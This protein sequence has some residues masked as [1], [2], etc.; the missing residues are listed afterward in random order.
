M[1]KE[2]GGPAF[3]VTRE[4][5]MRHHD[6]ITRHSDGGMTLRDYFAVG[7]LQG[8]L[9]KYGFGKLDE[10]SA[11]ECFAACAENAYSLADAMLRARKQ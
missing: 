11:E 6:E 4:T 8:A 1:S 9:S 5:D 2:D 3:P 10:Y 7:A